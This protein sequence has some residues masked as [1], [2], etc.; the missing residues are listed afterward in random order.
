MRKVNLGDFI[1]RLP[2]PSDECPDE[3]TEV[4]SYGAEGFAC[5]TV[6]ARLVCF[7]DRHLLSLKSYVHFCM[8]PAYAGSTRECLTLLLLFPHVRL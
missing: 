6:S 2:K 8:F 4:K 5:E 1:G 7:L 3:V